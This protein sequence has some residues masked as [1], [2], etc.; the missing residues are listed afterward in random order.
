MGKVCFYTIR[1]DTGLAPNPFHGWCTLA[2]CTPNHVGVRLGP[3]DH[4][5]GV[6]RSGRPPRLVFAMEVAEVLD[7]DEYYRDPRFARKRPN[8]HGTWKERV[9][10]SIYFRSESGDWQQDARTLYHRKE[11]E[12]IRDLRRPKAFVGRRF[13]YFG[14]KAETDSELALPTRFHACLPGRGIKY[15][16]DTDPGYRQF[17]AW[18]YRHGEGILGQP[19][20]R[21]VA[22]GR[23]CPGRPGNSPA[24]QP[25][26]A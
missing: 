26:Q 7:F 25:G 13:V 18:A 6:F 3:G 20:D 14:E 24:V 1:H 10:D 9:G 4:I 17:L 8:R 5:A 21:R 19:R 23:S 15:L 2:L 16:H 22:R 11:T 12:R